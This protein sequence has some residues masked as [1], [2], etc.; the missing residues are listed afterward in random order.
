MR[1]RVRTGLTILLDEREG[2][3]W[4]TILTDEREGKDWVNNL[5]G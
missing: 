3:N 1:E 2:K 4:L 5:V